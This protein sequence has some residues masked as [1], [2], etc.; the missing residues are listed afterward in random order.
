[1]GPDERDAFRAR[2]QRAEAD[3]AK[4]G[5]RITGYV[6][7]EGRLSFS[8]APAKPKRAQPIGR[9]ECDWYYGGECGCG[10]RHQSRRGVQPAGPPQGSLL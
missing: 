6:H 8:Y 3:A 10:T 5:L 9:T 1:M 2:L 7:D 4:R